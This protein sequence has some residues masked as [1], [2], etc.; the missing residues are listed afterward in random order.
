MDKTVVLIIVTALGFELAAAQLCPVNQC[1]DQTQTCHTRD[2]LGELNYICECN[3]PFR[4]GVDCQLTADNIQITTCYGL[5]CSSG[6]FS[7]INYPLPYKSR[8]RALYLL[9][10]PGA[11]EIVFQF[12]TLFRIERPKDEVY[13]GSGVSPDITALVS[14]SNPPN[15]YFFDGDMTP[16]GTYSIFSDTAFIYFLTDKNIEYVGF[17]VRWN[18]VD[19][20]A[21]VINCPGDISQLIPFGQS[22]VAVDWTIPTAFDNSGI[23]PSVTANPSYF[24]GHQFQQGTTTITYTATDAAFNSAQ[25]TFTITL[26]Q[27][28]DNINP[29]ITCPAAISQS[30]PFGQ[31]VARVFWTTP[32][33]SD[34]SGVA[35]TVTANPMFTPGQQFQQGTT[36]ITYTATDAAFNSAS[37]TF[38]IT[39]TQEVDTVPPEIQF[40]PQN[41]NQQI[42]VGVPSV[43][44]TWN[45]PIASDN[46]GQTPTVRSISH[47]SGSSF[48]VGTSTVT[49]TFADAAGN[50]ATCSFNVNIVS[51]DTVPPV[52][53][54]PEAISQSIPFGQSVAPVFWTT[55]TAS[56]NSGVAP[57]VTA[58][59]MFTP[60]QQFQ[61]GTTTITYTAT[62]AAFNSASCTFTITLTQEVDTVP[63]E[64]QFCPQNI[65]QQIQVGVPSVIVTWNQPIASDNSGQT[66]TVRSI[67]HQSGSSFPVG[68]STVTYTFADAAGNE[69][70]CSFNVNIVSVDTVPPVI[71]CP[72]AISQSIPFGQSVAPVFW[73]T[74]TAFDN[75]GVAPTVT[76]NPMF[77]PGQQ[78]QQGTTTITYTATDAAFNSA[79]C[80]FTITLTQE[81]DTV[82]PEIQ[83]CPQNINQQIQVGVPSV[84]VTWNQ[85]TASDNSGQT[86]TVRSTHQSG[87]SFPVGT[88][89]VTYTFADAA[90]NEATC[91]FNVNIVSVD[92]E[93]PVI[94][95]P[96]AISQS[97]PFGQSVAPVFWAIPAAF[98]NSGI[99]PTVT[100]NPSF[101]PGQQFQLGTT[102]IT[103]TATDAAFNSAS[104]TFTITLTQQV[105]TVPPEIQFC[106][107]NINQQIQ[108]GVPSVIVTWNQPTASDNSGQTPTV[109]STHQSGSSF[110]VGTSTVTY[111]FADAAG[112]EA[113]CSFNVNIVSVDNE[114][115]VINCPEAISQSIPF[116]QSVAPVFWAIPAAFDNSGI[117]PTVT[118]NPSFTPGQQFQLGTTTI[119]YTATDAAFNSASCTFT[120]T[121]TQQVDTVPPEI[122]FCPQNINQQI[123]VGVPSVIV[124]WNQPTASDNSGQTPTVRSTHQSGSSFPVGTS[125]VTYT[126]AD[127][128]GNEATCSFNVN[129]VSVD[130]EP[131]VINC[132]EAI[133]QSIPFGQSVAPVFW[134]I[135]AAFDNS[136]IAPTVTTNPSFTP[137]QQFQLGTTTITYTATDAAFNSASCTFTITLTQQ[138]DTVPPEIQ[139]CPQNINQQI[140]VGV[141]SVIVTWN[142]P[143]A[144][145]N[146]GQTPT[147]RSTHQSGSSFPVGTSTVTYT[148]AD[149]AGNEATC[150]FNVNI[151]SVDTVPPEIQFCPQNINQQIQVGVPSVIVTWNQPTASDNSGQTPTVRSTHQ[152]GSSFPVGTSTVTYTFADAAG[153]EA[154]CSFNVNIVSVDNEPPVINCPEAISQSIPFGQ[155]V[156]PVFW[157]IPAAF[158]NSGIAPTVTTNPSFTPGQQFQLGTTTITYTATDAA[159]NS[160]SCTFTIT[161]T[162]QVD[163]VPPEIQFC[164]QNINQQ[165]QVGV[166]SVIVTWNQPTASDNSGQTPTV[167][168]THQSGSSFPVGTSTVTYTFA[169]A[170]GNEATCSFNVNIVSVDTVPP[171]IQFCPQNINQ[172]I[173]VGVPSVI[174]TWNQPTASDNS[175]QTPTVRSTHQSGSS[176]PVGT[177]TV[178]YTFADAAGNEATCSFNVNIVSVD[179]TPPVINCPEAII[180]SIPFGQSVARVFWTTP[181]ASDNSGVAPTVT[182]NP[183]YTPGQQFQRGTTTITYTATDAAFNSASCTFTITLT[184]V[185]ATRPEIQFCPQNINQQIEFGVPSVIVLWNQPTAS[186]DSGQTPNV[187]TTHQ[188]GSSFPVGTSTVIYTFTDAAGNEAICSFNVNVF[189]VDTVP[190]VINCPEAISQ[191]IPFGQSVAPVFWAIPTASDN[192]G[193]APTVTANPSLTPGQQFQQGTT[194]IT[195]TATDAAFNSASCTFTITLTQQVDTERPVIQYCPPNI[196]REIPTGVTSVIV[197]WTQPTASDNSGQT[198]TMQSTHQSGSSFRVGTSTVIYTFTDAAGNDNTCSF[199]VI[200][201]NVDHTPPEITYCPADIT[202]TTLRG[203]GPTVVTWTEP[204]ANDNS[205]NTPVVSSNHNSGDA[206][207]TTVRTSVTYTFRDAAGNSMDCTFTISITE[208]N[209]CDTQQC[210]NGGVCVADTL[211]TIRCLC[212]SCYSGPRCQIVGNA[213]A[214]STCGNGGNCIPTPGSCT[215][216]VC[217]CTS[218][219]TGRF[220]TEGVDSCANHQCNNG[221][222]CTVNSNN[223]LQ[224]ICNC[225]PCYDGQFCEIRINPCTNHQCQNGAVCNPLTTN[226]GISCN[227]Y[228]CECPP[229]FIGEFCNQPRNPCQPN[230][231]GNNGGCTPLTS[232]TSASCFS[233]TC[234]CTGCFTGYNCQ[235]AISSPCVNNPCLNG[236]TCTVV[237]GMCTTHECR[238]ATGYAGANCRNVVGVNPNPCNSFPCQNGA[239]CLTMDGTYYVCLCQDNSLGRNCEATRGLIG[240]INACAT[241]PCRNGATCLNSY[242]SNSNVVSGTS[243]TYS[244]I[245]ANGFT[246]TNCAQRSAE[247]TQL[248]ICQL[249]SKPACT[250]GAGCFNLYHNFDQ[251]IDYYCQCPTGWTG[252]NCEM[253]VP[254]SC[255]SSPCLNGGTCQA[256]SNSFFCNC[257][258]GY[259]GN[260]CENSQVD[261]QAPIISNCPSAISQTAQG[262]GGVNVFWNVPS[263]TDNS[264]FTQINYQ[265]HVPGAFFSPGTTLVTYVIEDNSQNY[266]MCQFI[267][268]V[269]SISTDTTAPFIS[270]CPFG[271]TVNAPTG[272]SS[273]IVTW[274]EPTATDNSGQQ[275]TLSRTHTPGSSFTV[276][277]TAVVYTFRDATGN[278]ASC[279]FLVHVTGTQADQVNVAGCQTEG[280]TV[281]ATSGTTSSVQ[282]TEPTATDSFGQR[283]LPTKTHS[284]G[285]SFVI[286][287]S[288]QVTYTFVANSGAQATCSFFVT[289][290]RTQTGQVNVAGCPT[291]GITVTATS[292]TTSVVQWTEPTATDS[293]G[294]TVLP[295][296]THSPGQSFVIGQSTQVTY[297]F[298]ANSGAQATCSFFVTVTRTTSDEVNV[299]GCPIQGI[300]A[301]ATSGSTSIVQWTEPTATDSFGQTVL[302][303]KTHS[304]GQS[305][306]IGQPTQVTYTFVANSGAQATCSFFVTVTNGGGDTINPVITCP[307]A[308]VAYVAGGVTSTRVTW[309]PAT[310]TDNSGQQPSLTSNPALNSLFT[311]GFSTVMYTATDQSGNRATCTFP[312]NVVV[313]TQAPV[314]SNCPTNTITSTLSAGTS[315]VT[316]SW[317]EPT[318]NDNSQ[319]QV[320]VDQTNAPGEFFRQGSHEVVY[321][322]RDSVNNVAECRFM[323]VVTASGGT[324]NAC[325]SNPC[326]PNQNCFF[327]S[328]A[329]I[330]RDAR[331]RRSADV[332]DD[333]EFCPCEN[334][335]ECIDV[336]LPVTT[337]TCQPGFTGILC[338][339]VLVAMNDVCSPNP[340]LNNGT[341]IE[342]IVGRN[343]M[344]TEHMCLCA[345][346]WDGPNCF[347]AVDEDL[348]SNTSELDLMY[349]QGLQRTEWFMGALTA[350]VVVLFLVFAITIGYLAKRQ[351]PQE[352]NLDDEVAIIR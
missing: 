205:G 58:N 7:S 323:V 63:P 22:V 211:S 283:V 114:P 73:T 144:S 285:Q 305:F 88:S 241:F 261:N 139:F 284:P 95:C 220:C 39:L 306:V 173:Q 326:A 207:P 339:Q 84:I 338:E 136:G 310:A 105:D 163:T 14:Q 110:P 352:K 26:T 92:N 336:D 274:S 309:P 253:E 38:S 66:P 177:S 79:S 275:P 302:P 37:C 148:F 337:C 301:S 42:Q 271:P 90:G 182:T 291:E 230:P 55:P 250:R 185:D 246:G 292:G 318:A 5:Q 31:S 169:D 240:Q 21:P 190:P 282:W 222:G 155:S 100:T 125:T 236:G 175:G 12:D 104:C 206:F 171:E 258:T 256:A 86:P 273:A 267:V 247:F 132:P 25:C 191:S 142:Q 76:A 335:G 209:P 192:S 347:N 57:T 221:A 194:T 219:F 303:T 64:I 172:Q 289:V 329:F 97:I 225:P 293:F 204:T 93:P 198:P 54:C 279:T 184:Q 193:L 60:G 216:Y 119:T 13:I 152:S 327:S 328:T 120:I 312:V 127:A 145:D 308:V 232:G 348:L 259:F 11:T 315:V 331:R 96:E 197:T 313:D 30:I 257:Q 300:T 72:E 223:C 35:P 41:I 278:Q 91:S 317:T 43:I 270:G 133:S 263:A 214:T 255:S 29:V 2:K 290:T 200:V 70:T 143:T 15:L 102:T 10:I 115:P 47:Q 80:T 307:N 213:C 111:T 231:C 217:Q 23:A 82:P 332:E 296:K 164:P 304:P 254:N 295:T 210:Q 156:A 27:E 233:Y 78:F 147:V 277:Y 186:D 62:D 3:K 121:L 180:Q 101:T 188:P 280:I 159:F 330:C 350:L 56:D 341:C 181:T 346:G 167:R 44:V 316:V 149:A 103:Y 69:A 183:S 129:I 288:T 161:L 208:V 106:P 53:N 287:Q 342:T 6:S 215:E 314:V 251:D 140:Q 45:Q 224:Y 201:A 48:P 269:S 227:E 345:H 297:T 321:T 153:N 333:N 262:S 311:L 265:S 8:H 36:T 24:P 238:C 59:P 34:N 343:H 9:Y 162:Q 276:G 154:T 123:Q 1:I 234:Q 235:I 260:T 87:S 272:S 237:Q 81:V 108:V 117:A 351:I 244:C 116:G 157:A 77:T 32:N 266:A 187:Q 243:Q 324:G 126:F 322:F 349:N 52:I 61:Q 124:T 40:C 130:N 151:V 248:N 146:S 252:H 340:C 71:N 109:R 46:S 286:G 134:A 268:T 174:V 199:N 118:T 113:T 264:G 28:V 179:T 112:N 160:A 4:A 299:A 89:T 94:N 19:G 245:C 170:A 281:T 158:D 137:G 165:I 98:D 131:P 150:S 51:V 203:S 33:A 228:R 325:D 189:A 138:V 122:Q 166:P 49:Y 229:C 242:H 18:T 196:N 65:N 298:V 17:Q 176:F 128:A 85:P 334:G 99:A 20:I 319:L 239:N 67:S 202:M 16:P 344:Q 141:P 135:P 178:T 320:Q 195:Y 249:G 168:S 68:T 75:S 83:F 218:C 212:T 294:Q 50:E 107:Q 74:P 226:T